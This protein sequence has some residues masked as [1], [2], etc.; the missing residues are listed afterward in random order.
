M[1]QKTAEAGKTT[2][3]SS[4]VFS[5]ANVASICSY[6]GPIGLHLGFSA[7]ELADL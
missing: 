7:A 5:I 2:F 3:N 6:R 1:K 4:L